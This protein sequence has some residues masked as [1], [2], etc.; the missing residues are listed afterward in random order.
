MKKILSFVLIILSAALLFAGCGDNEVTDN[1]AKNEPAEKAA[2][3]TAIEGYFDSEEKKSVIEGI[4]YLNL[5]GT[6]T[7]YVY[8]G[9]EVLIPNFEASTDWEFRTGKYDIIESSRIADGKMYFKAKADQTG[10]VY[11]ENTKTGESIKIYVIKQAEQ[12][13]DR[14]QTDTNLPYYLYFEKGSYT[15]F[16]SETCCLTVYTVDSDGYYTIPYIT[17][18]SACGGSID[19]TPTGV[20]E[21]GLS[22]ERWHSWGDGSESSAWGQYVIGYENAVYIHSSA[23]NGGR[24]EN[25]MMIDN[26]GAIGSHCTG[27]CLRMQAGSAYWIWCNCP[28]GTKLEIVNNNPLGT[29]VERPKAIRRTKNGIFDPTDPYLLTGETIEG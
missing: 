19:K 6:K 26:Y 13:E 22:R 15:K 29:F 21:I 14:K 7:Y 23:T 25:N 20:H 10:Y 17:L 9:K 24:V 5:F 2:E 16:K 18:S 12:T 27:G 8:P 1:S 4:D 11:C 3:P 28:D